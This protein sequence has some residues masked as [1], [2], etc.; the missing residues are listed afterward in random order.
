[1]Y[2]T[3]TIKR[4]LKCF[5]FVFVFVYLIILL[6]PQTRLIF[7]AIQKETFSNLHLIFFSI[8]VEALPFVILGVIG[9]MLLETFVSPDLVRRLLPRT[10]LLGILV[11]GLLGILFP[12]CECGLVPIVRRLMEKGVPAPL[13]TVF[14]LTVPV[15]NP[16][17]GAA[18]HFAFFN[19]PDFMY[20]RLGGAYIIAITVG[21]IILRTWRGKNP[22]KQ[23][24][25]YHSCG[26]GCEYGYSYKINRPLGNRLVGAFEHAQQEF[27]S[28]MQ[29]LII[30]A[31]LASSAQVF[32]PRLWLTAAG[33][34]PVGSVG[35]MMGLAFFLSI[36]SGADAFVA[37]TFVN[38]FTPGSLVAF[39]VFGPMV[40]LKNL[41]MML[42]AFKVRFV[43][44]LV[45]SVTIL[46]LTLGVMINKMGVIA[47]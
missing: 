24:N 31:F 30:G 10:W 28:I 1:M 45:F 29:Y 46:A 9:S 41:M 15:I 14:L 16:V 32:L 36:C 13:A 27:F 39:M 2:Q 34:H 21:F 20:W 37:N 26:C 19:R 3:A 44:R 43:V 42:S 18:T 47:R 40:D 25:Y 12:F 23:S 35:V 8:I 22:L 5:F 17:V 33:S 38:I 11:S 6:G 4:S 7:N